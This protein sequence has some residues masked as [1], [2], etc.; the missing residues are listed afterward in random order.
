MTFLFG[1]RPESCGF[2][3]QS[4]IHDD[5]FPAPNGVLLCWGHLAGGLP[6][7]DQIAVYLW[8]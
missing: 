3:E 7:Q 6:Y 1:R 4:P 5:D 2:R 8:V